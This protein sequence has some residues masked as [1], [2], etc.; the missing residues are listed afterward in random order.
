MAWQIRDERGLANDLLCE[1]Q[2]IY[3][4]DLDPDELDIELANLTD[5]SL[6][7]ILQDETVDET[8]KAKDCLRLIRERMDGRTSQPRESDAMSIGL[9]L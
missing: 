8:Q 3:L 2:D 9:E 6:N 7:Q 5:E 4:D 1:E